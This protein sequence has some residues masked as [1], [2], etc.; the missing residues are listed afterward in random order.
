MTLWEHVITADEQIR[1]AI[2]EEDQ[3]LQWHRL[4]LARECLAKV[5]EQIGAPEEVGEQCGCGAIPTLSV[6]QPPQ[7]FDAE[8]MQ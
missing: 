8:F 4:T 2:R 3:R 6:G 1:M 5:K 7:N